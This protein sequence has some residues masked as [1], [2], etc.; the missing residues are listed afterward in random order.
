MVTEDRVHVHAQ[1]QLDGLA[2]GRVEGLF[3]KP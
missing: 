2:G 3:G 1:T